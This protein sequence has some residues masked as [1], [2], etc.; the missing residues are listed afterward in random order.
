MLVLLLR[1]LESHSR[2]WACSQMKSEYDDAR[3]MAVASGLLRASALP[4][5]CA[6]L[7]RPEQLPQLP[8]EWQISWTD[9]PMRHKKSGLIRD[10]PAL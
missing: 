8:D 7:K 6:G 9:M 3:V 2:F 1:R 4:R 5:S 10:G